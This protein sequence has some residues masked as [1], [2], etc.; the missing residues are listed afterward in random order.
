MLLLKR[1]VV[2]SPGRRVLTR[3]GRSFLPSSSARMRKQRSAWRNSWKRLSPILGKRRS[4]CSVLLRLA[5]ISSRP[6]SR[7][8]GCVSRIMWL[9]W[10]SMASTVVLP[11]SSSSASSVFE[12]DGEEVADA[13]LVVVLERGAAGDGL[14]VDEG[15][16]AALLVLDEELAVDAED[17]GVLAADRGDRDDDGAI[18]VAA[19]DELVP[20]QRES[21]FP[22]PA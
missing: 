3:R 14:A 19:H 4:S 16:V 1:A 21:V 15:A 11:A 20:V 5:L 10:L 2:S 7:S 18:R 17:L 8:A 13:D 9:L 12:E 6:R 22:R